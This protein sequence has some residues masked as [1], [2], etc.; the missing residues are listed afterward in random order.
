MRYCLTFGSLISFE[1]MVVSLLFFLLVGL[2]LL[3]H[4]VR[5]PS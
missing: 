2:L 3:T 1:A 4:L 5:R